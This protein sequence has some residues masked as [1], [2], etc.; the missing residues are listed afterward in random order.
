[1]KKTILRLGTIALVAATAALPAMSLADW[2]DGHHHRQEV[3][4]DWRNLEIGSAAL[5]VLGLIGHN[6]TLAAVGAAGAL[7][8]G[9]RLDADHHHWRSYYDDGYY[10]APDPVVVVGG[11]HYD[12]YRDYR[13]EYRGRDEYR[14]REDRGRSYDRGHD[15]GGRDGHGRR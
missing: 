1:M 2:R 14:G 3:R 15:R 9:Y 8:S 7:Y 10:Y 4:N 5:G 11:G 12:H 6:D 13:P